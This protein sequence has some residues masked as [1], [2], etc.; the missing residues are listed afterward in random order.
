MGNKLFFKQSDKWYAKED[1]TK[2]LVGAELRVFRQKNLINL[3]TNI[4]LTEEQIEQILEIL[5][6]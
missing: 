4:I 6:K 5:C 3:L 1:I 2:P